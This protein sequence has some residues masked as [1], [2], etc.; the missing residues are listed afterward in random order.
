MRWPGCRF[1]WLLSACLISLLLLTPTYCKGLQLV[2][3]IR[4]SLLWPPSTPPSLAIPGQDESVEQLWFSCALDLRIPQGFKN[5]SHRTNNKKSSHQKISIEEVITNT[6]SPA[7]VANNFLDCL[8]KHNFPFPRAVSEH[9]LQQEEETR[10]LFPN[11]NSINPPFAMKRRF[12]LEGAS[13]AVAPPLGPA[14][15][16]FSPP[17]KQ[18]IRS[19]LSSESEARPLV[20]SMK[21][22]AKP[23]PKDKSKDSSSATIVAGLSV[24]CIALVALICLCCCACRGNHSSASS[25]DLRDDKPLLSLNLSDLSGSSRKSCSTPIDVNKLGALSLSSS[26][27]QHKESSLPMKVGGEALSMKSE[28]ERHSNVQAMKLS[29]HEITTI[30][31]RPV[32]SANS[33]AAKAAA[34]VPSAN[35]SESARAPAAGSAPPPPPAPPHPKAPCAP[36]AAPAP[37][38]LKKPAAGSSNLRPPGPPPPPASRA[39]AGPGP[40]PPPP[41]R[42]GAGPPPPAMPGPPKAR[43]PPPFKKPGNVAGHHAAD[44][45]KT[46]LK[47]FFWDKVTANPEQ[48][49]VWDQIKAGSFQFNEEMIESLFGCHSTDKKSADGKKDLTAKDA[50]QFVRILE[51]KKAQNLAISLK[52]LSVSAEEVRNA[53]MEG[54]ELPSDLIQTLIRWMPTS[55]EELRLRLYTGELTQLGPAEQFLRTIIDIPYIFQRLDALLF[56]SSLP[57]E[58]ANAEQSFKTLEVACQELRN[59]RLFKKLLEAVLKTGN[60]MND[61]TFRGGAQAFKLDTLLKLADVKGVDGKTTLLHFVVQEII[62]SEGVR[63]VRAAKEQMNSSI[64]SVSSA[65]DLTEDVS[66]DTE[67]YKQLGLNVVSSLGDDLQNVRKA[68]CLDSD[69]LTISVVSLGHKLVKANEFL[70]TGMKSLD[71]DSGFH[72]K[73]GRF[74]EQSQVQVTHLLEEEKKLRSLVRATVDYFHGSTGKDE[75]LRLFVIVRDFLAILDKVCKEV[76]EAASKAAAAANKKPAA[77]AGTRGRQPSQ[78]SLSFRDPRQHL[79]P[80]IQDRR[81]AAA[82]SSSSSSDSDDSDS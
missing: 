78:S 16:S 64:S 7:E 71:E 61:G 74:I 33:L 56:M 19:V 69:A 63:A 32:T 9:G 34:A 52:A 12:L 22:A 8:N 49:M 53:V 58:A 80:A 18:A 42:A 60:R 79:V 3:A 4:S 17:A 29:S 82:H 68:A 41:T 35:A 5:K 39:A 11:S 47:P 67:H 6:L 59:S 77:A 44:S 37:P 43:G 66:D 15:Y 81:G 10:S 38:P 28:F 40:P 1:R 73:L 55:D 26:E 30:G 51:P 70:N 23:V 36:P 46:K 14:H 76:K 62:R 27:S 20:S 13:A 57:E 65:D 75:G 21:K 2:G 31:G 50:T 48:T 72:R 45:N 25:Y 54:H 24:S